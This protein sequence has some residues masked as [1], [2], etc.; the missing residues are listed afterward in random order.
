MLLDNEDGKVQIVD[1]NYWV[2]AADGHIMGVTLHIL[3]RGTDTGYLALRNLTVG[4]WTSNKQMGDNTMM[5][6]EVRYSRITLHGDEDPREGRTFPRACWR[7][8]SATMRTARWRSLPHP[9]S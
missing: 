3:S 4:D 5:T 7:T 2:S 6:P 1:A 9:G 8:M